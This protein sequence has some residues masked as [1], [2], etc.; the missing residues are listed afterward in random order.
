MQNSKNGLFAV[1]SY[2]GKDLENKNGLNLYGCKK[3]YFDNTIRRIIYEEYEGKI[4]I[5]AL[6]LRNDCEVYKNAFLRRNT[7]E[8]I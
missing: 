7:V 4:K 6:G 1:G 3:I 5:L 2:M 8:A